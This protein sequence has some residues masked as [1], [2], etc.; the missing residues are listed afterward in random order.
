MIARAYQPRER[1]SVE[2]YLE[3]E[4]LAPT[5]HE[6]FN[7]MVWPVG[8]PDR[9]LSRAEILHGIATGE[10]EDMA[11]GSPEH[12][13]I[14]ANVGIAL[15]VQLRGKRCRSFSSDLM[16]RLNETGLFCYPDLTIA[17]PPFR[18]ENDV[19]LN[20][21]VIVEVLSSSTASYDRGDKRA[22][23]QRLAS[24]QEYVLVEQD[25]R[26]IEVLSRQNDGSWTLRTATAPGQAVELASIGCRLA[27]DEVYDG[28]EFDANAPSLAPLA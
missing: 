7:G 9:L 3:F 14:T 15:G 17:C 2:E 16:V 22:H 26:C 8:N 4:R 5:K 11:G 23:F 6:Y 20:P 19:L 18:F 27:I 1:I 13:A 10:I 24:F 25:I 28:V 21:V 12:A